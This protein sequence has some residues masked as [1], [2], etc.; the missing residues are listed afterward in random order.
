MPWQR[1]RTYSD[2]YRYKFCVFWFVFSTWRCIY[3]LKNHEWSWKWTKLSKFNFIYRVS[4]KLK[5]PPP[6]KIL[7]FPLCRA[8]ET[9]KWKPVLETPGQLPF[10]QPFQYRPKQ[11]HDETIA[12][13]TK[14]SWNYK[15]NYRCHR[16][17]MFFRKNNSLSRKKHWT[18]ATHPARY[19]GTTHR[20]LC[21]FSSLYGVLTGS[22]VSPRAPILT[23]CEI[24]V[25]ITVMKW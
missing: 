17:S 1:T 22:Y 16:S 10:G 18:R 9:V 2:E 15:K 13:A 11:I 4:K 6:K 7:S 3:R 24:A 5:A 23:F 21:L 20:V 25:V 12:D 8:P 19:C 14:W